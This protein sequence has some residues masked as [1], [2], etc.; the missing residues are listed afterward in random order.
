[1]LVIYTPHLD[2]SISRP[3]G[4][5]VIAGVDSDA[6]D[7]A[8]VATDDPHQLP[9]RVPAWLA[10]LEGSTGNQL[11]GTTT[12]DQGLEQTKGEKMNSKT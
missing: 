12:Q 10:R 4:E 6:P 3:S 9:R 1:M 8:E 2:G 5:P 11:L 7:P